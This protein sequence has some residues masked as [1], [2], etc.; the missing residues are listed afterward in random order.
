VAFKALLGEGSERLT[1]YSKF[2]TLG[3]RYKLVNFGAEITPDPT[4]GKRK[5]QSHELTRELTSKVNSHYLSRS[6]WLQLPNPTAR[7][8]IYG[9]EH[10]AACRGGLEEGSEC[11][12]L[13]ERRGPQTRHGR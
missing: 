7:R 5:S 2:D 8:R 1:D 9:G 3:L 6:Q 10:R 4:R 11:R 12:R 13:A